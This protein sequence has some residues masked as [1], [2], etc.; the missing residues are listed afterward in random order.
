M[1]TAELKEFFRQFENKFNS[2]IDKTKALEE[3]LEKTSDEYWESFDQ[4][5]ELESEN[6]RLNIKISNLEEEKRLLE[7]KI[8]RLEGEE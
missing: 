5:E 3:R 1:L 7:V 6:R 8:M 2:L 4:V